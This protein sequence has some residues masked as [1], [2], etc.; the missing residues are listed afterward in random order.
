MTKQALDG[1][2]INAFMM[3][4]DDLTI[5]GLD[6]PHKSREEHVLW[7]PRIGLPLTDEFVLSILLFGV[8]Q[9]VIPRKNGPLSEVVIG[10]QRVRGTRLANDPAWR[11]RM[12][13][14]KGVEPGS[15]TALPKV[16]VPTMAPI[17][18]DDFGA[19]ARRIL[20]NELRQN[21]GPVEKARNAAQMRAMGASDEV[22][23]ACFNCSVKQVQKLLSILDLDAKVQQAIERSEVSFSAAV[24]LT[25]LT[26]EQQVMQVEAWKAAG[27]PVSVTEA[28]RQ[29]RER[30]KADE[31]AAASDETRTVKV[32]TGVLR[33]LTQ[34]EKFDE[35]PEDFR[36]AI[37]WVLGNDARRSKVKGLT[38]MLRDVGAIE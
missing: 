37:E 25:D 23:A 35:L 14:E 36:H 17:K 5:V 19:L 29:R 3:D 12:E 18:V 11:K 24:Q 2:R 21:D 27:A 13:S 7:D 15:Y 31:P 10:R 32:P 20:E 4:P 22:I 30:A 26:R 6:T 33:K 16:L 28:K 9:P 34:H 38:A 1:K 8:Q